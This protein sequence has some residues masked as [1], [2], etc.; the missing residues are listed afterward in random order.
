MFRQSNFISLYYTT[1]KQQK[2]NTDDL[3]KK[4]E[5]AL[6]ILTEIKQNN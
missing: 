3:K 2:T 1:R 4:L 6:F 5:R